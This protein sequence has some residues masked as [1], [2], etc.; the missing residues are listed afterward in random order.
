MGKEDD[1]LLMF[2]SMEKRQ[3][4]ESCSGEKP[5][6][7]KDQSVEEEQEEVGVVASYPVFWIY[8]G[9]TLSVLCLVSGAFQFC[10]PSSMKHEHG[11]ELKLRP[12]YEVPLRNGGDQALDGFV[13]ESR[14]SDPVSHH[15]EYQG[16]AIV[17]DGRAYLTAQHTADEKGVVARP[18]SVGRLFHSQ[19]HQMKRRGANPGEETVASF[20]VSFVFSIENSLAGRQATGDGFAFVMVPEGNA[21]GSAGGSLGVMDLDKGEGENHHT[22]AVEFDT[23]KN[24][25]LH[26]ISNN[27]VGI[28]VNSMVSVV[29]EEAGYWSTS[30]GNERHAHE[31]RPLDLTGGKIQA[32]IEYDGASQELTVRISPVLGKKPFKPLLKTSLDLSKVLKEFMSVGFSAATGDFAAKHIIH[33]WQF[34]ESSTLQH[35]RSASNVHQE[36]QV[37]E[38]PVDSE[39]S[40][41]SRFFQTTGVP[42]DHVANLPAFRN[43]HRPQHRRGEMTRAVP[44]LPA[45]EEVEVTH[46]SGMR[47]NCAGYLADLPTMDFAT[48]KEH[49]VLNSLWVLLGL[50]SAL[51]FIHLLFVA[52]HILVGCYDTCCDH[53]DET[54]GMDYWKAVSQQSEE[55][56]SAEARYVLVVSEEHQQHRLHA[57]QSESRP[58]DR[59]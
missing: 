42:R 8:V 28:N 31:F 44:F 9:A 5:K 39:V 26:D 59:V 43:R 13:H 24:P 22:F 30:H 33:S 48:F 55:E 46:Q 18:H 16:E 51:L 54:Q 36:E 37:T 25:S 7:A 27:H 29:A 6:Q 35:W 23:W 45:S 49:F 14:F 34:E 56:G 3:D 38:L 50:A 41:K 2:L 52:Y 57:L 1:S 11:L 17:H 40:R 15:D 12:V 58:L 4:L 19:V 47:K 53:S 32:W 10:S 20:Q 21:M